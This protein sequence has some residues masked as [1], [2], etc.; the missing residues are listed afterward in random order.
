MKIGSVVNKKVTK[1]V[2]LH[3]VVE[4]IAKTGTA[5]GGKTLAI[6]SLV[7]YPCMFIRNTRKFEL[8]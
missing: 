2:Y 1:V 8:L 7:L 5:N 3:I 4:L 6:P